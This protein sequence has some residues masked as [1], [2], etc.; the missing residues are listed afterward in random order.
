[1][2][3]RTSF[4]EHF[5]GTGEVGAHSYSS[6]MRMAASLLSVAPESIA[7][8]GASP[9]TLGELLASEI[10]PEIGVGQDVLRQQLEVILQNSI[11]PWHPFPAAHLHTPVLSSSLAAE[12]ILTAM[13]QSMDSFDQAP[14]ASVLEQKVI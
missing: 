7:Y 12:A 4:A 13:N 8:S 6:W 9:E 1:M 3:D 2:I 5:F 10:C 11:A 14:A